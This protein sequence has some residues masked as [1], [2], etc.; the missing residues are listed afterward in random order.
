MLKKALWLY[1][2]LFAVG[3]VY[4]L[5]QNLI[6]DPNNTGSPITLIG[7]SLLYFLPPVLVAMELRGRKASIL[8][9]IISLL[10]IAFPVVGILNFNAFD[11]VTIGKVL[12]FVPMIVALI[13]FAV[14]RLGKKKQSAA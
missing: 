5:V 8:L 11:L 12:L 7:F 4:V 3:V 14:R 13:Y 2:A 6:T 1:L 10:L 9:V